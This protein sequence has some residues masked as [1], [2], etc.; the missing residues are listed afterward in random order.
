MT[1]TFT[2][3]LYIL[4]MALVTYFIRMLP[5]TF[6]QKKLNSRF[7][8]SLLFYMP[9]AILS[10]MVIPAVFSSTGS[11]LTAAAG[12]I[13]ALILAYFEQSL[14]VVALGASAAAFLAGLLI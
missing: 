7:L 13:A 3:I 4:V 11:I 6:L 5:F 10:A 2:I 8:R 12:L 1:D 14:I 9:Y